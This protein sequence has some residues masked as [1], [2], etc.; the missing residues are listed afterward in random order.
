MFKHRYGCRGESVSQAKCCVLK[1]GWVGLSLSHRTGW[2]LSAAA[3]SSHGAQSEQWTRANPSNVL[4]P[5]RLCR[6]AALS[7]RPFTQD[8]A[9]P[10]SKAAPLCPATEVWAAFTSSSCSGRRDSAASS[11]FTPTWR[12]P[13]RP[14]ASAPS[15]GSA[16]QLPEG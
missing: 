12:Q 3:K 11:A 9:K 15:P 10:S 2:S 8:G 16:A 14:S 5:V 6:A 4:G 7:S 13:K 1:G